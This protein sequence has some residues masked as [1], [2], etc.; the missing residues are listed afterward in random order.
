[1]YTLKADGLEVAKTAAGNIAF[2]SGTVLERVSCAAQGKFVLLPENPRLDYIAL[3]SSVITIERQGAELFRGQAVDRL[4][5]AKG[6][7]EFTLLGDLSFLRDG[8][9]APFTFAGSPANLVGYVL[10]EYNA[11]V[12]A[13]RQIGLG[14]VNRLGSAGISYSSTAYRSAWDILSGLCSEYGGLLRIRNGNSGGRVL[15]WMADSGHYSNQPILYG[16]NLLSLTVLRDATKLC[17]SIIATAGELSALVEDAGSIARY[18]RA[19]QCRSYTAE[20]AEELEALARADLETSKEAGL[21]IS[22]TAIDRW[23][24][25]NGFEPFRVGDFAQTVDPTQKIDLW[26]MISELR[27]DLTGL[28]TRVTLG[29]MPTSL[30]RTERS[31]KINAWIASTQGRRP[32]LVYA[33]DTDQAYAI[34]LDSLY[35]VAEGG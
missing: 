9:I 32:E 12:T 4:D 27:H 10:A 33:I 30:D 16:A 3:R 1:M 2:A 18:G 15:D 24:D 6:Y 21:T 8:Q 20:T 5:N 17:N 13:A 29:L 7:A 11:Q 14:T 28:P 22:G 34:D 35:A 19:R 26:V 31:E 25:D 23:A